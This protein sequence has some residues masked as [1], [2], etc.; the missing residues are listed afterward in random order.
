MLLEDFATQTATAGT[1]D[2]IAQL[3][4]QYLNFVVSE[5][6]LFS[7][8]MRKEHTYWALNSVSTSDD[9][10]DRMVDRIVSGL[11]SV[12]VTMGKHS[13][14]QIPVVRENALLNQVRQALFLSFGVLKT[15]PPNLSQS[16]SIGN[17]ETTFSTPRT[18]FSPHSGLAPRAQ[19][20]LGLCS[21]SLIAMST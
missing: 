7:L 5:P 3:F 14:S 11:F 15:R 6:D 13:R 4:D 2:K 21:S 1:S 16:D 9:D 8:G 18:T 12:I 19:R 10:L 17:C 20:R